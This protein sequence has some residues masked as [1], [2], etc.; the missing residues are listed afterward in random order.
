[1]KKVIALDDGTEYAFSTNNGYTAI[2]KLLY[3]LNLKSEDKNAKIELC[4][5]RTWSLEHNGKTYACLA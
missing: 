4:N 1:M 5:G 2:K 3:T